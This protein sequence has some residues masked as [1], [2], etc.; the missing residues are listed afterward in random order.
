MTGLDPFTWAIILMLIGC[1]LVVLEVFIPSGGILGML[2]G[3]AILGSIIFAFRRDPTAGMVFVL[4]SLVAVPSLLALAFR[5]WPH[6][7]MGKAFLGELPSEDEL[8]PIDVR[9]EL[10]GRTGMAKT[11]ML[12][13][14]S[15]LVDGHWL[16]AISQG[17]AIEPGEPIVVVEVRA[18]RV[19]VRRAEP[20]ETQQISNQS[21]DILSK[22]LDELDLEG[23][24]DEPLG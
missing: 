20:D 11:M 7:P 21:P 22:P 16:D 1:A 3:F 9:R 13:S 2:S 23:F 6:T 15:V 14:G 4:I 8:K 10:V 5:V 24:E 19:V 12:P 17:D 18:N